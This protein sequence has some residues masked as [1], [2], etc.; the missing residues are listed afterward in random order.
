MIHEI[1]AKGI[2]MIRANMSKF[3]LLTRDWLTQDVKDPR[4][5]RMLWLKTV[6]IARI[7]PLAAY[8]VQ[9]S[10]SMYC[11]FE[12]Q[13]KV[14]LSEIRSHLLDMLAATMP[15]IH[16]APRKAGASFDTSLTKASESGSH[17]PQ[18]G[19]PKIVLQESVSNSAL[20]ES[21]P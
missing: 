6:P 15:T 3:L 5:L 9:T 20:A 21:G 7:A 4:F 17:Q 11:E 16:H 10:Q 12:S 2:V 18:V 13:R 14:C 8:L 19:K 1:A